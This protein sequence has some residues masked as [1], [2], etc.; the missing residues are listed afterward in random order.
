MN[1]RL[2]PVSLLSL[3]FAVTVLG[4]A[5][6][7]KVE[8]FSAENVTRFG[9]QTVQSKIYFSGD[10]W[11]TESTVYGK[12]SVAIVRLD[13]KTVWLLMPA[14]K[15]YMEQT[16][17]S[18]QTMGKTTKMPGELERKKIGSEKV[19][20]LACDKYKITYQ[21]D[22]QSPKAS[23]YQWI[24]KDGIPVKSAAI[25]GTWSSEYR[26]I[27]KGPQPSSLFELPSGYKKFSMPKMTF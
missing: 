19:G 7:P 2:M 20:G 27:K 8:E 26:K 14:Q 15:M 4:C 17:S 24:S 3:I 21:A 10:K 16:L 23:V 22:K 18:E 13:K 1:K 9:K 6:A 25:D 5:G 11:R 12:K